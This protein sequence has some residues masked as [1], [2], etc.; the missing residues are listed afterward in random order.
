[1]LFHCIKRL[2]NIMS[3][4]GLTCYKV[5]N[6]LID[7]LSI[8]V[9]ITGMLFSSGLIAAQRLISDVYQK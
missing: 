7:F 9:S 8:N 2:E 3:L 5:Q 4:M 1:M 6:G